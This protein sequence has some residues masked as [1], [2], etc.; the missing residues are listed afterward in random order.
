MPK[1]GFPQQSRG[2]DE[3]LMEGV[4]A[5]DTTKVSRP[6]KEVTLE[7]GQ[8]E[9]CEAGR[10]VEGQRRRLKR[11]LTYLGGTEGGLLREEV[12]FSMTRKELA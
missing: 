7:Q 10:K 2:E 9:S 1:E 4:R 12:H 8:R 5:E 11:V 6:T 3:A